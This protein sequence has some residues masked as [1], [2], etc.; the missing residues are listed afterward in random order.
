M[1]HARDERSGL[2]RAR[3]L[4][5][6]RAMSSTD[7]VLQLVADLSRRVTELERRLR[8]VEEQLSELKD[9]PPHVEV[10]AAATTVEAP[11]APME[12]RE[13]LA[14][15]ERA[16]ILGALTKHEWNKLRAAEELGIP[17]RTFYR[18]LKEYNIE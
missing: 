6:L 12:T 13:Q 15:R 10:R 3:Q 2:A 8:T 14:E 5:T 16:E 9:A 18:R 11:R 1:A 7:P 4:H 17:R